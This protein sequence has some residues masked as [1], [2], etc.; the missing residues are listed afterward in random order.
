MADIKYKIDGVMT[1]LATFKQSF[2]NQKKAF[3]Y[4]AS[5]ADLESTMDELS[6][7]EQILMYSSVGDKQIDFLADIL[8]LDDDQKDKLEDLS[9]EEISEHVNYIVERIMGKTDKEIKEDAEK[10]EQEESGLTEQ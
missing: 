9:F 4:Q 10:A 8:K 2:R 7:K 5:I 1:K 6:D 3:A